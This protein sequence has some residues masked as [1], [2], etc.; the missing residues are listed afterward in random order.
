MITFR[1][2]CKYLLSRRHTVNL[3]AKVG[4]I[5]RYLLSQVTTYDQTWVDVRSNKE[6]K[7]MCMK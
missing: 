4:H 6:T 3:Q 1:A 7:T 2:N 5:A